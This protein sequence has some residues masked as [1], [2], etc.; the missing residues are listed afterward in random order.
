VVELLSSL[1]SIHDPPLMMRSDNCTEFVSHAT[2]EWIS[3]AGI[4]TA[5][6]NP[7]KPRRKR[8][9]EGINGTLRDKCL[10]R[11]WLRS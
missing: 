3:P 2:L 5:L 10:S 9:D 11:E 7:C 8:V 6:S 4:A 1:D